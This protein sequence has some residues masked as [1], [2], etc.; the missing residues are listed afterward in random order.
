MVAWHTTETTSIIINNQTFLY[1]YDEPTSIGLCCL[2]CYLTL[3]R[4]RARAFVPSRLSRCLT[5]NDVSAGKRSKFKRKGV[6]RVTVEAAEPLC[7]RRRRHRR[8]RLATS[9]AGTEGSAAIKSE[10]DSCCRDQLYPSSSLAI[11][12]VVT[13]DS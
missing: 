6:I 12:C 7:R 8:R 1:Y 10:P 11:L 3:E 9:S 5:G 4:S 13:R 2:C